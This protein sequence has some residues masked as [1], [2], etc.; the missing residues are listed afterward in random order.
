MLL[1]FAVAASSQDTDSVSLPRPVVSINLADN[2]TLAHLK[3]F[4]A[5]LA[6]QQWNEAVETIRQVAE[7]SGDQLVQVTPSDRRFRRYLPLATACQ[8]KLIELARSSP[9]ALA[10]YRRQV[11]PAAKR[12]LESA[13][14][15]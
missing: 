14:E 1:L 13:R 7:T 10:L 11:D 3:R 15:R 8:M 5:L 6:E 9:K 4:D 2:A 12:L